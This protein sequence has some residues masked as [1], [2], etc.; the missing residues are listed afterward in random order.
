MARILIIDDDSDTVA[1]LKKLLK[2][3]NHEVQSAST[4]ADGLCIL[5]DGKFKPDLVILDVNMPVTTGPD[6]LKDLPLPSPPIIIMTGDYEAIKGLDLKR[7][8]MVKHV[9]LK[10]APTVLVDLQKSIADILGDTK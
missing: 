3:D 8:A 10:G 6:L 5:R 4:G 7:Y 1:A 9:V 2:P